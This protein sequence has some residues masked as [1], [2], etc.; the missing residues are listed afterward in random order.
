M[1]PAPLLLPCLVLALSAAVPAL[2]Q[3]A[4][5]K[6][7]VTDPGEGSI[8]GAEVFLLNRQTQASATTTT[9]K[10][11]AFI[12]EPVAPGVYDVEVRA[13]GFQPV[14]STGVEIAAGADAVRNFS[15]RLETRSETIMVTAGTVENAYRVDNVSAA[16]PLGP[17]RIVDLPYTVNVIP[18][19]LIDDTQSRNFKEAAKYMPLVSF[20]E[21]QGPE[22]LRPE[23]R[24]L[25]GS[26]MQ[27]DRKDGMGIA[28]TTPSAMEEY[29][30]VEIL[31]GVGGPLYGP[32]NPSGMFNF[33]TKRPT[34]E[35][36]REFELDY[37]GHSVATF[38][39]DLAGR[40]G[41]G[42]MFGYRTNLVLGDGNGYVTGS[43][44]RRQLAA[45]AGDIRMG[46]N[47]VLEGNY[48]YYNL[49]QHGYPGWFSYTPTLASATNILLPIDAPDPTRAGYGQ[50]F[51]GVDLT[52]KIGEV[53]LKHDFAREWHLVMGVLD[54]VADRNINTAVN[55][56]IDNRGDYR[57]YFANTFQPTLAPR[58]HV[59][60]D[61]G[62]LSGRFHT[63]KVSHMKW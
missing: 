46:A 15:L 29:E 11:G 21:M 26:N 61:L 39:T 45:G 38:H 53:R 7:V 55:S 24:G 9:D 2:G 49:Y 37:E 30:Q 41:P 48:S 50:S 27:N 60:S 34:A 1:R 58:F 59:D 14:S 40:V 42:N 52:S 36:L 57:T 32:A 5:L 54:Q 22:V 51:S 4:Q 28:V 6:G 19:Q 35:P 23:T 43:Q 47:T 3:S 62:Y 8:E 12:F 25:Q 13:K 17:T 63:G 56:L 10:Q 20:Q 18:R 16:G 31:S 44:L 33:V